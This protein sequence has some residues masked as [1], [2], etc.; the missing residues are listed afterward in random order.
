MKTKTIFNLF[1]FALLTLC[2]TAHQ[3]WGY[4]GLG[5]DPLSKEGEFAPMVEAPGV[6]LGGGSGVSA[7]TECKAL[8][9]DAY[10]VCLSYANDQLLFCLE[11][12]NDPFQYLPGSNGCLRSFNG[13]VDGPCISATLLRLETIGECNDDYMTAKENCYNSKEVCV[14]ECKE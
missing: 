14:N 4:S 13:D 6:S 10:N 8:C 7:E 9:T 1:A 2:F 12:A 5:N 3:V 11:E